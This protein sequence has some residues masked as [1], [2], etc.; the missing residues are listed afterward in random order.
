[1]TL[2]SRLVRPLVFQLDPERAHRLAIGAASRARWALPAVRALCVTSD[3]RLE[4]D[5]AGLRFA[6][7]IGL[8]AGFDKSG[9]AI[10]GLAALGFGAVEIGSISVDPSQ[11]NPLP[12][13]FRLP[14]DR[15]IVV[16][17]GLP[18]DG[19]RAVAA[20]LGG[21]KLG[22]PLGINIVKTNRG[23]GCAPESK[24]QIIGEYVEAARIL[25][26]Y[27][28]YLMFNLS[29]PN[30]QDGRDFFADRGNLDACLDAL[31]EIG[32]TIPVFLK[33][34][35]LGGIAA[36][37]RVLAAADPHPF[38]SGFMFNLAPG[39]PD[40]LTTPPEVWKA[41]PGAVSG[42]PCAALANVCIRETFRRMD[43]KRHAIIGAGGVFDAQGAY[44]KIRLGA[45][46]VQLLTAL[47]YEGPGV[48]RRI[49][50]DL[51]RLLARDGV[52]HVGDAVGVDA[53]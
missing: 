36:I 4:I 13:L 44:E 23:Q 28:N 7:P 34:S 33:V 50:R 16:H 5:V 24:D 47:V 45:S 42:Q 43:R 39:K 30:T 12:R 9:T 18:N 51:A 41:M 53:A 1:M 49:T 14:Q 29:C 48:V 6:N 8:A 3:P 46:L 2:Y 15:A 26:P 31:G 35:P 10:E 17:Y 32:F 20:R 52:R 11:G 21:T 37:E 25:A 40:N 27:A 38:V 22:C 19:A